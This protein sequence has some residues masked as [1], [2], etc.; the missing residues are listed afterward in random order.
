[1]LEGDRPIVGECGSCGEPAELKCSGCKMVTYCKVE[2]QKSAWK[3]H[4]QNCRFVYECLLF[5]CFC[6]I[7]I[8]FKCF[9]IREVKNKGKGIF[10]YEYVLYLFLSFWSA[11]V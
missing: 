3:D 4:R 9:V 5:T 2:C 6:P 8:L 10:G 7:F 11:L 1:M